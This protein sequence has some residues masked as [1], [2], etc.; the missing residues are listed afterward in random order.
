[1]GLSGEAAQPSALVRAM[2]QECAEWLLLEQAILSEQV[3]PSDL[4]RIFVEEVEFAR[5][6]RERARTRHEDKDHHTQTAH[7]SL[8]R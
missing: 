1:M 8:T 4:A 2:K 6:Y 7:S 3:P 5:W